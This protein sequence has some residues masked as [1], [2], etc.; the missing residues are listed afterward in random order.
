VTESRGP[1][2]GSAVVATKLYFDY[3]KI[4]HKQ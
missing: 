4:R 1:F 2:L 3:K